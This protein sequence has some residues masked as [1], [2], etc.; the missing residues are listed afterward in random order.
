MAR[1]DQCE[2]CST[3]LDPLDLI[4]KRCKICGSEPEIRETE[5]FYFS[6]SAFQEKLVQYVAK[7]QSEKRTFRCKVD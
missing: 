1:G 4:E 2:H 7:A 6:F 3:I 5:H